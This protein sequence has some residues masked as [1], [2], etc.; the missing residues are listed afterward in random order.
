[1]AA[2]RSILARMAAAVAVASLLAVGSGALLARV[3]LVVPYLGFR[4]FG[5]GLLGG[6]LAFLLG[7]FALLATRKRERR[8]E[9]PRAWLASGLG[10]ALTLTF[11]A[12]AAPGTRVPPI[13]DITTDPDDPP[14]FEVAALDPAHEG[15]D[16]SY[17]VAFASQQR[18][19]YP[20]LVPLVLPAPPAEAFAKA[21]AAAQALGWEISFSDPDGFRFEAL[22]RS[23]IFRFVDD[24]VVRVRSAD[25]GSR[26]DVRSKSRDG[27][28]DLGANAARIRAFE[29]ALRTPPAS[30]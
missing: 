10:A 27:R 2:N 20:D 7:G 6:V 5:L 8:S 26:V 3:G 19:A 14:R 13:N 15:R 11:L 23:A 25:S 1:M 22:Q 16:L 29:Q 17:P 21:L 28:S 4:I 30:S 9:R 18:A 24:V 12:L